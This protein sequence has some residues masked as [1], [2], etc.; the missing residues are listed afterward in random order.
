MRQGDETRDCPLSEPRAT[1]RR[2]P[3]ITNEFRIFHHAREILPRVG[4]RTRKPMHRRVGAMHEHPKPPSRGALHRQC[5][6]IR[7]G[8]VAESQPVRDERYGTREA[9]E[10]LITSL[11]LSSRRRRSRRV[12]TVNI[13]RCGR[14]Q[15]AVGGGEKELSSR[16]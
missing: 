15:A 4:T 8:G 5:T 7:G 16:N 13:R 11:V 1:A 6:S 10:L 14:R 2:R 9:T 3:G 12:A